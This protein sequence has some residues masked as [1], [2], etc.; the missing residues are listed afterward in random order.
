MF[1]AWV[2]GL[3]KLSA[4][5]NASAALCN[6]RQ[7]RPPRMIWQIFFSNKSTASWGG[8]CTGEDMWKDESWAIKGT[9]F[10]YAVSHLD[11]NLGNMQAPI[12]ILSL[13]L[14]IRS[15]DA[16]P[17]KIAALRSAL[18]NGYEKDAKPD[19]QVTVQHGINLVDVSLCA[20]RG[21]SFFSNWG[22]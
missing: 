19:G 8:K 11:A 18:L 21:V 14:I 3:E 7:W 9:T 15:N 16:L 2:Q 5:A 13:V 4:N 6:E 10:L 22:S 17:N 20:H 12:L 1:W